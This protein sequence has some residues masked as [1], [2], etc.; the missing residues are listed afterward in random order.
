MTTSKRSPGCSRVASSAMK[1]VRSFCLGRAL[2]GG[3]VQEHLGPVPGHHDP[4]AQALLCLV[5]EIQ[6][7]QAVAERQVVVLVAELDLY[8]ELL[9]HRAAGYYGQNVNLWCV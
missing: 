1:A 9:I 8:S 4:G 5:V 3:G 7:V 6:G 2:A